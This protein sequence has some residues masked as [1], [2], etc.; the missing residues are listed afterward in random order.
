MATETDDIIIPVRADTRPFV[1]GL[2]ALSRETSA[3][4]G[5]ITA[6][7]K[8]AV[9]GG[10]DFEGVLKDLALRLADIAFTKALS[11]LSNLIG[12]GIDQLAGAFGLAKGGVVGG[13]RMVPFGRGGVV[14]TPALFP[15]GRGL[16]LLGEAGPE[17]VLPLA[18]GSDGALGVQG[19][20]G[21][22]V[23]VHVTATDVESFR[24][25]EAQLSAMLA[26]AVGR[27][28]RGL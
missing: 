13:G 5:A 20:G 22:V 10:K 19:G 26:R 1:K 11:P 7:F 4:S 21:I 12:G 25:S 17:A 16:G 24:K 28:R 23:N 6:T 14:D 18:R 9:A 3:F 2:E 15:L 27:G 8:S